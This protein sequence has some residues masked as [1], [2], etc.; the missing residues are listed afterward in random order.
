M[1]ITLSTLQNMPKPIIFLVSFEYFPFQFGGLARH[2][3]EIISRLSINPDYQA[4]IAVPFNYQKKLSKNIHPVKIHFY[5]AKYLSYLE[6]ALKVYFSYIRPSNDSC[7]VFFSA[8]SYLF[9]PVLPHH[10]HLFIHNTLKR[11]LLT[12]YPGESWFSRLF[13]GFTYFY[14]SLYEYHLAQHST[15]VFVVSPSTA[16]DVQVHYEINAN[17]IHLVPNGID[18]QT[19]FPLSR[20]PKIFNYHLISVSRFVPRK[21]ILDMILLMRHLITL[22]KRYTLYLVGETTS[23][24]YKNKIITAIR[25][26]NLEPHVKIFP[27]V[28]DRKINALYSNSSLFIFTSLVEGFCLVALEALNNGLPVIAYNTTALTDIVTN[29]RNGFL[30][31]PFDLSDFAAKIHSI[32]LQPHLYT[33]LSHQALATSH[34]YS[35]D[36]TISLLKKLLPPV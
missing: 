36:N 24:K 17:N 10:Y 9:M 3:T 30:I 16:T 22:D 35:W 29:N 20:S 15:S 8:F 25:N 21:N 5:H 1:V 4:L 6:F 7:F 19:F 18:K 34:H 26:Y 27:D 11:V 14:L 33:R 2:A 31:Q 32:A 23:Q 12:P 13:R 28:S